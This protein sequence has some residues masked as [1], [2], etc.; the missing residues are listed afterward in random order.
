M[1]PLDEPVI[2]YRS[3]L[4]LSEPGSG[5]ERLAWKPATRPD[6][7]TLFEI[8]ARAGF[9]APA[10]IT[11]TTIKRGIEGLQQEVQLSAP[12]PAQLLA[13][14]RQNAIGDTW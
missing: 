6:E 10:R 13:A 12:T 14:F 4:P 9:V 5:L 11:N 7:I 8:D 3:V 2:P 1:P